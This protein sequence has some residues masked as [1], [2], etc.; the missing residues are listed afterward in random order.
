MGTDSAE[1]FMIWCFKGLENPNPRAP[2]VSPSLSTT[3]GPTSRALG[4]VTYTLAGILIVAVTL[5]FPGPRSGDLLAAQVRSGW[6]Q[7][8]GWGQVGCGEPRCSERT[9][10][11]R[12]CRHAPAPSGGAT[13]RTEGRRDSSEGGMLELAIRLL[14]PGKL[15]TH[16][17][18]LNTFTLRPGHYTNHGA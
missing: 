14:P 2:A 6:R 18:V 13:P 7:V 8:E 5:N 17:A 9:S 4:S 1:A 3:P 15:R 10:V 11:P 12:S 16:L